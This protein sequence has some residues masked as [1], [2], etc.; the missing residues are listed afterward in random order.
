[1]RFL[2]VSHIES[3]S[4]NKISGSVSFGAKEPW[5]YNASKGEFVSVSVI[6]E[7]IGQLV[8][9]LSLRN[10]NFFGRPVFLFS[11]SI[12]LSEGV[13]VAS[14]VDLEAE[15]TDETQESFVFSGRATQAGKV[16]AEIKDCGG[17]L[18]PLGELEDPSV[19]R[20]RFLTLTTTGL[21]DN[22]GDVAFDFATLIDEVTALE[23]G[24][25]ITAV[26]TF[27]STEPF[28]ADHFPRFPVT[29][30]VVINE[31]I[32]RATAQ[33]M[34]LE[35]NPLCRLTSLAVQDLKIKSF[36]RPHDTA[37]VS[38]RLIEESSAVFETIAEVSLNGKR[39][40]R[41]RYRYRRET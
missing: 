7:A 3:M 15:I 12:E 14:T 20:E 16:I 18:M 40:L 39:I 13:P 22:P 27:K 4:Q 37:H 32:A 25:S 30:I 36:I 6:S 17:Y 26:K 34:T 11:S 21:P 1:M 5:R 31:M 41:G 9:W 33:M 23:H 2:F 8:S 10:T 35:G 29:P 28:Y 38:V 24:K 19:T